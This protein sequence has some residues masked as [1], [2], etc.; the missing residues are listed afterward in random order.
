MRTC[1]LTARL[2]HEVPG[3]GAST[4]RDRRE[5]P[6]VGGR[7]VGGTV[8]EGEVDVTVGRVGGGT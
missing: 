1:D 6:L 3:P 2:D 5:V 8:A 7:P 4:G